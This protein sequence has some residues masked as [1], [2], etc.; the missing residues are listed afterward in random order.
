MTAVLTTSGAFVYGCTPDEA[1]ERLQ[2]AAAGSGTYQR[3][4]MDYDDTG[5]MRGNDGMIAWVFM[6]ENIIRMLY[7]MGCTAVFLQ[8]SAGGPYRRLDD[9]WILDGPIRRLVRENETERKAP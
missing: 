7:D 1:E 3:G 4:G 5:A 9:I 2:L 6:Q 8:K